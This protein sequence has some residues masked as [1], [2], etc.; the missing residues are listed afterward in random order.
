MARRAD[1]QTAVD[2]F[3]DWRWRLNNLYWIT[4]KSGKRVR[5]EMNWTQ[6]TFFE[7]MH[8]LNVLL[9]ARQLGLT[10]GHRSAA[11]LHGGH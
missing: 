1:F 4:D 7:Q 2:Q 11:C 10:T 9:K 8:Y 6:M 5:F 3:S